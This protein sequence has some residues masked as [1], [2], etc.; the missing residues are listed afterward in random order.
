[1]LAGVHHEQAPLGQLSVAAKDRVGVEHD[2]VGFQW[3]VPRGSSPCSVRSALRG[4]KVVAMA[5]CCQRAE[6]SYVSNAGMVPADVY[7]LAWAGDP[8]ISPDGRTVAFTV[9]RVDQDANDYRSAI[10]LAATDRSTAPRR[11]TSGEKRDGSPRWSPDGSELAFVSK[12]EPGTRASCTSCHW[13]AVRRGAS[14]T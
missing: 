3:T 9:T 8:R 6:I 11:L 2:V 10:Y 5:W 4:S 12:A 14:Q 7:E 1:M 13:P